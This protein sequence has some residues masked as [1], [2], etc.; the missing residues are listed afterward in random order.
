MVDRPAGRVAG[1]SYSRQHN[2]NLSKYE[3]RAACAMSA[4]VADTMRRAKRRE[5]PGAS[6]CGTVSPAFLKAL[7][8]FTTKKRAVL[9]TWV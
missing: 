3:F 8:I 1:A 5:R 7:D 2:H 4:F 9:I 6:E